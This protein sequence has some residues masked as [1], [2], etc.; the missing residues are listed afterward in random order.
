MTNRSLAYIGIGIALLFALLQWGLSESKRPQRASARENRALGLSKLTELIERLDEHQLITRGAPLTNS[1]IL[2]EVDA[3][4]LLDPSFQLPQRERE[5]LLDFVE[6]GGELYI[7]LQRNLSISTGEQS[8]DQNHPC[9]MARGLGPNCELFEKLGFVTEIRSNPNFHNKEPNIVPTAKSDFYFYSPHVFDEKE[10]RNGSQFECYVSQVSYGKGVATLQLGSPLFANALIVQEG[11]RDF[12]FEI[13]KR[14]HMI[15]LDEYAIWGTNKSIFDLL[16]HPKFIFPLAGLL[17]VILL[18]FLFS[19]NSFKNRTRKMS[20]SK[21]SMSFHR[22]GASLQRPLFKNVK[23]YDQSVEL[24]RQS[25][26]RL[27]RGRQKEIHASRPPSSTSL[28]QSLNQARQLIELHQRILRDKG[29][30]SSE[31]KQNV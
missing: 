20:A 19:E 30:I 21:P 25:L 26:A 9:P 18:F 2:T 1:D 4:F 15:I 5:L 31:R 7:Q 14:N 23:S 10:C 11:N 6:S 12:L 8:K 24:Y 3:Y 17:F 16:T 28:G 29:M 13:L 22:F 27:F